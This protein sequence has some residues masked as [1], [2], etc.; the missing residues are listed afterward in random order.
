MTYLLLLQSYKHSDALSLKLHYHEE[1]L[2][3]IYL[4]VSNLGTQLNYQR[5]LKELF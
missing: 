2:S 5:G 3:W 1:F 4:P